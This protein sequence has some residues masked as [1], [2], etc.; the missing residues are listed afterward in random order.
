LLSGIDR[1]NCSRRYRGRQL[2]VLESEP[3]RLLL[4]DRDFDPADGGH[5]LASICGDLLVA[6]IGAGREVPGET[7]EVGLA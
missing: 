3:G 7:T 5:L 6:R 1:R 2:I 4:D